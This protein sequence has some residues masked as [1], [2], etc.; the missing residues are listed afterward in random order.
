MKPELIQQLREL[1]HAASM[2]TRIAAPGPVEDFL[3]AMFEHLPNL[4]LEAEHQN[5]I[6]NGL[7]IRGM[8]LMQVE[9]LHALQSIDSPDKDEFWK[10]VNRIEPSDLLTP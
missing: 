7:L 5:A 1:H 2:K 8:N 3:T 9:I 10:K 6:K 4:L